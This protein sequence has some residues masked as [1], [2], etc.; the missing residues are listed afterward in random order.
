MLK[1]AA[2]L[3]RVCPSPIVQRIADGIV[4][5]CLAVIAGQHVLPVAVA[6]DVRDRFNR[7]AHYSHGV[8]ILDLGNAVEKATI[9]MDSDVVFNFKNGVEVAVSAE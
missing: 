9:V 4:G 2:H 7:R 5:D 1:L 8:G 3:P 6:V